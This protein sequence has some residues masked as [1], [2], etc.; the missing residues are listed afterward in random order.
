MTCSYNGLPLVHDR[1]WLGPQ[2]LGNLWVNAE[3]SIPRSP[4]LITG[5]ARMEKEKQVN[6]RNLSFTQLF[7]KDVQL[8]GTSFETRCPH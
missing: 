5:M 2:D 4:Y 7:V 1:D 8:L 6:N 3:N